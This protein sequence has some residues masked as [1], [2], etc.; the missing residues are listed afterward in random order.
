M[1]AGTPLTVLQVLVEHPHVLR[2]SVYDAG[3]TLLFF[4]AFGWSHHDTCGR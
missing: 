1:A 2:A 4:R 3:C